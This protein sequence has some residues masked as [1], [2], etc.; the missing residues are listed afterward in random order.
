MTQYLVIVKAWTPK[1][2]KIIGEIWEIDENE[3]VVFGKIRWFFVS[4]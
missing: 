4:L 1:I 3:G 2:W